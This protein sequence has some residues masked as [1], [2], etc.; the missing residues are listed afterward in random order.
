MSE[1]NFLSEKFA[2]NNLPEIYAPRQTLLSVFDR[3]ARYSTVYVCAPAGSGKTVS[4]L[5]W[6]ARSGRKPVWIGLD[7]YDNSPSVFYKQLATGIFSTQPDNEAMKQVLTDPAFSATPVEHM[8]Q[9][10]TDMVPEDGHYALVLDDMHT[11]TSGEI[12]KSLPA[13][14]RRLPHS[15]TLLILSRH[16][17]PEEFMPLIHDR[18][19][20]IITAQQLRFSEDEIR[21]YFNS[22]GRFLT[23]E[24]SRF[25]YQA[26][27]GWAMGVNTM[28]QSGEI[29]LRSGYIFDQYFKTQVW[30]TWE[31]PLREFCLATAIADE[32]DIS[33]ASLLTGRKDAGAVMEHLS[34]T[35]SFLS[36]LHGDT[37]RYHHLFLDFL[38]EQLLL[39][40]HDKNSALYKKAA[41][42]YREHKDYSRA[43]RFWLDS[44]DYKGI[45]TYLYL[46]LFENNKGI[47]ADYA[48]FLRT[49]FARDFPKEAF[50][51]VPALHILSAWYYY[52]TSHH[53]EFEEHMDA[54]YKMLPRIALGD[55]KFVEYAIL[56]Y[57]VDHRTSMLTKIRQFKRFGRYVKKFTAGG[58]A[59][60]IASFSHNMPYM[61]RSNLDYTDLALDPKSVEK[62]DKTFAVLLGAEWNY[63]KYGL[64][65]CFSYERGE[66]D[67]AFAENDRA[68]K[69]FRDENK[70]EG[71]IC[72]LILHHS[73]LWRQRRYIQARHVLDRLS[74]VTQS[75]AQ[76]FIPNLEAYQTRLKLWDGSKSAASAWL[77]Q[78]F[79][80]DT[81]HIELFRSFQHF[82]TA[83]AYIVLENTPM[84]LK[85]C[86]LLKDFGKNV[87][88]PL[89][90]AEACVLL[91]SVYWAVGKK[92]E[93]VTELEEALLILQ[94][95]G[96]IMTV[97]DEGASIVA[98]LKKILTK[99]SHEDYH[100]ALQRAFVHDTML[101][102][103]ET[104]KHQKGI[105][106]HLSLNSKPIKLSAQQQ[107]MIEFLSQG[108]KN[109]EICD[110][111][112]LKLTT[113]KTHISM[114]YK[115]LGVNN[116][117]D[118]VLK[119]RELELI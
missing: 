21:E 103:Y 29:D 30:D 115:K 31:M 98:V 44:G 26:T 76:F 34:Q 16:E 46:F 77:D 108:Y 73:I 2:P 3:A 104:A 57:S 72:M 112:G 111:T 87:R 52:L 1:L 35:N 86:N 85:Y 116:A 79:V 96:F 19:L 23:P 71:L 68:L 61:H 65:A 118:A 32:F 88:R 8:V 40:G 89:D 10:L 18:N 75:R 78:Y 56:A 70:E 59:T 102:A 64:P 66:L 113:V 114:A 51:Q 37:Y 33:L 110:M 43:L 74:E 38:R 17:A 67:T 90:L 53:Q 22:L 42:Y 41:I 50:R 83:R 106:F 107:R 11:I 119:A 15:F 97:S 80:I 95:Y 12:R 92:K 48:D 81:Q 91:S 28:A 100:G 60:N 47:I 13:V 109:A 93:A 55:S 105:T 14:I 62:L 101:A 49:F 36:R 69:A 54:V 84:A 94:P 99:I 27:E 45:D 39:N 63:I 24:E 20:Q 5:L 25:A 82:T 9:L 6:L 117:M 7:A 4:A 58:L